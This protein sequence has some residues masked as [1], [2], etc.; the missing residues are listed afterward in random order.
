M[1]EQDLINRMRRGEQSAFNQ[2]FDAYAA[3]L[4]AFAARRSAL[5]SSAIE[6]VVQTTM[7]NA[8]RSLGTFRGGSSLFTW[9]CQ[10]CRNQLADVR[11]KAGRQPPVQSLDEL[12]EQKALGTIVQLTDFR[13]PLDEC[14]SDAD[15]SA[16]RRAINRLP[17]H[18][19]RILELR[20]GDE[21]TVPE[22]GRVLGVSESAAES[23]LVRARNAF[24]AEWQ[25]VEGA[26]T[27]PATTGRGDRS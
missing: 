20:Y 7:I 16:V 11:R 18:Y 3:R 14:A 13:D 23:Q 8:M 10:I 27:P 26:G 25:Q 5:D 1:D 9:L 21:L 4:G 22:I 15:R 24:R 19:A 6:D 2:F 12:G 17:P